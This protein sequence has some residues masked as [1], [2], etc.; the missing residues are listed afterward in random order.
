[1]NPKA[2]SLALLSLAVVLPLAS[3]GCVDR[4][5]QKIAKETG[6][7][8]SSPIRAVR[9][10]RPRVETLEETVDVSGDVT[11]GLDVQ[12]SFRAAGRL[13]AVYVQDGSQVVQGQLIA[14]LDTSTLVPQVQQAAAQLQSARA[15][16]QQALNNA[17]LTPARSN[18]GIREAQAGL[19]SAQ[20]NLTK[21]LRGA[22][23]EERAQAEAR[24]AS[25]RSNVTTT[26]KDLE[27]YRNLVREGAIA[28]QRVEQAQN[29]YDTAAAA[30][31]EAQQA[32]ATLTN[33]T[34]S[35]D[36]AV[37]REAVRQAEGQLQNAKATRSLDT[38]LQDAANAARSQ[39]EAAAAQLRLAQ[40]NLTDA[41]LRAPITGRVLGRPLQ[42]GSV[43]SPGTQVV[44]IIGQGDTY[45]EGQVP[46]ARLAQVKAGQSVR[47]TID[48]FP[49]QQF[50][51][52]IDSI[53]PQGEETGRLF[54]AR[55]VFVQRPEGIRPGMF[56][57]GTIVTRR[58][59]G[60]TSVPTSA[61]VTSEGQRYVVIFDNGKAK[62]VKVQTGLVRGDRTQVTG[63]PAAAQI[64]IQGASGLVDGDQLKIE[65][66]NA[67]TS[68][69][70]GD[71]GAT[72][73]AGGETATNA[74]SNAPASTASNG[75]DRP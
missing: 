28:Q 15:T 2:A 13:A 4:N 33:G 36:I 22:R 53:A 52:R 19:R 69:D 23:S 63:V 46:A 30:L 20:A 35:E 32:L 49:D 1:M 75:G 7:F 18:A 41:Q 43:V 38:T 25:A 14:T 44:R 50:E 45:F 68:G 48:A 10:E 61:L 8:V 51:G 24:V 64:V 3:I 56:A 47:T 59:E 40:Q 29:A 62:R 39:V 42:L 31:N 74:A 16:Y 57:R 9:V 70:A 58:I 27:R 26:R 34:R 11:T 67:G 54:I 6:E 5:A 12:A 21:A 66:P 71:G 17:R 72:T 65:E 73:N 37:A 55:I 60:A